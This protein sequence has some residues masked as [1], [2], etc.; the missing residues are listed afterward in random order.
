MAVPESKE[1][2]IKAINSQFALLMKQI[3]AVPT[4]RAFLPEMAGHA[5]GTLM[6]PANLVAYLLG[7]GNVVLKWHEHEEQGKTID[8]PEAGYKWNQLGLL[9][10]KFYQDYAPITDWA[11][12]VALLAANKRS[13]IALVERYTDEQ[14]YGECW[15]GKWTRGRMIQFNTA[16]PYKNAAGRL[17][18]WD[19]NK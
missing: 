9:A 16:S 1:A 11:E 14:L 15:Y 4:E 7:W 18:A 8:F 6:S 19:K 2:L 10:Q 13:L 12:L 17:R 5:Q 3:D